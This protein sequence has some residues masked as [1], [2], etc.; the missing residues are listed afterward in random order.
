MMIKRLSGA[1]GGCSLK[2]ILYLVY[3]VCL[4]AHAL[5]PVMNYVVWV[6]VC[7][8]WLIQMDV[9]LSKFVLNGL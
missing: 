7:S 6:W 9:V 8:V 3:F 5:G 4:R 2:N 1:G